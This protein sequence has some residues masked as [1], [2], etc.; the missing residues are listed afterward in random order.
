MVQS[1]RSAT[2]QALTERLQRLPAG[3]F[4]LGHQ[5]A[6]AYGVLEKK[7]HPFRSDMAT[8]SG[9]HPVVFGWDLGKIGQQARNLDGVAFEHMLSWAQAA[10]ERGGINTISWHLDNPVTGGD[11]WDT[12]GRVVAAVLPGGSHHDLYRSRL[13]ALANFL[14][15]LRYDQGLRQ[16]V[17]IIIRPFHEHLGSWFWWGEKHCSPLE[18]RDLWQFTWH[19]LTETHRINHLLW[20]Y[21]PDRFTDAAH[22]LSRYPGDDYVDI[23]GLDDYTDLGAFGRIGQLT[24]RLSTVVALAEER[25]KVAALTETG[26]EGVPRNN[27]Y[28]AYLLAA[29]LADPLAARLK[30]CMLWRNHSPKHHYGPY[31][32]HPANPDFLAFV[33]HPAVVTL[34]AKEDAS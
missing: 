27:W 11:S 22:Y 20:A 9:R 18:Y 7:Y 26:R 19:Y 28:T 1:S 33:N 5:D 6:L 2:L 14:F 34:A 30:Y 3:Q 13:D 10:H 25:G 23:L 17:P 31:P 12:K 16:P 32:G 21:S 15:L 24:R 29:I 8:V 4:F